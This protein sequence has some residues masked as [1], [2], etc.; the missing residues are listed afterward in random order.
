[1]KDRL[2]WQVRPMI[3]MIRYHK[4]VLYRIILYPC[5]EVPIKQIIIS[6]RIIMTKKV[7]SKELDIA[8][9]AFA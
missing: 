2:C 5:L 6:V 3:G 1:M 4:P 8:V 7:L 9:L